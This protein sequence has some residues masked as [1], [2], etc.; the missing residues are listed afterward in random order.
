MDGEPYRLLI[1]DTLMMT[2]GEVDENRSQEM[3]NKIFKPLKVLARKH[4]VAIQVVHHMG[5]ADRARPGQ[6]MLGSVANHAWGED[7][8][9]L[10][11]SGLKDVRIDLESKTVPAATYR[12]T[13]IHNL[14]WTPTVQAWRD[15]EETN[16]AQE[17]YSTPNR[18]TSRPRAQR[19]TRIDPAMEALREAPTSGMST[20]ELA[21]ILKVNRSTVHKRMVKLLD[22]GKV[23]RHQLPGGSN[24]WRIPN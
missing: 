4:N 17:G 19:K 2:A 6:R 18:Q 11:R 13:D 8:M 20:S 9:Y 7:S 16:E 23:E 22:Q 21:D 10:S 1:I 24:L 14:W 5:K 3:T 12:M 15:D